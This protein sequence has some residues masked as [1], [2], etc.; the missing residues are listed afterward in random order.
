MLGI[1]EKRS[2]ADGNKVWLGQYRNLVNVLHWHFECEIIRI[3]KGCAQ[4][5]IGDFCFEAVEDDCFFCASEELHYIISE[6]GSQVDVLI[7]DRDLVGD[8]TNRYTLASPKIADSVQTKKTVELIKEELRLKRP[9][10]R[11]ALGVYTKGLILDIFRTCESVKSVHKERSDKTLITKINNDFSF[12][13]FADAVRYSGYSPSH[14]SKMFKSLSGM[15]FSEYLNVIKVE[16]AILL[17]REDPTLAMT[18]VAVKCGFSTIRNFNRVFKKITGYSPSA[19]PRDF[20]ID[21]G[22][23]VSKTERFDP[24]DQQSVLI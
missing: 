10:H 15:N 9:F 3:V 24:T 2:F 21:V 18:S 8:I 4:V 6:P 16:K 13:T 20:I 17:L 11:E 14:F 19:L 5:R 22:L 12:I 7:M 23:H 1:Y